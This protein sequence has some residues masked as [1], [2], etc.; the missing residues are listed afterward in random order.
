MGPTTVDLSSQVKLGSN[1]IQLNRAAGPLA[2]VQVVN[3]YYVPWTSESSS[4]AA[5]IRSGDAEALR[6][7]TSFN[8]T[9]AAVMEEVTCRVK[10]ERIGFKGYG[11]LLAEIGL[12]PGADVDR[13]SLENALRGADR[14]FDRYDVLPDRVVFYLWPRAGGSSFSFKFRPRLAMKA[15]SSQSLIY[16]YYNPEA[17]AVLA[18]ETFWVR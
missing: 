18:P 4:T 12:P 3:T 9:S 8:K 1:R 11:M 6:L 10:A 14:S 16:D 7:E 5:R 15:K 2:S 17:K 13:E